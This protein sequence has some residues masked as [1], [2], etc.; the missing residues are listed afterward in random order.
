M[1]VYFNTEDGSNMVVVEH[2]DSRSHHEKY[3]TWRTETGVGAHR[4][5]PLPKSSTMEQFGKSTSNSIPTIVKLF[6]STVTKQI[7]FLLKAPAQPVWQRNYY[8]PIICN[9]WGL[10]EIRKYIRNNPTQWQLNREHRGN[11]MKYKNN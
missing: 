10:F 11:H 3:L 7:T 1:D 9:E 5:V 2:W 6:K 8:E 4:N